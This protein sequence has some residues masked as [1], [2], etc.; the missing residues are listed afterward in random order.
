MT[1]TSTDDEAWLDAI[2]DAVVSDI[3][4]SGYFDQV[5]THEPKRKPG[6]GLTAAVWCDGIRPVGAESGLAI[7]CAVVTFIVR[8]FTNMLAEP[9]DMIDP[10]M[11]KAVSNLIRRW[12]D[13]FDFDLD[14]VVRNVDLLGQ[15]SSGVNAQAGYLDM[16]G[17]LFRVFD[18]TLPIICNDV[19]PQ[20]P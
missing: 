5:N 12:H 10:R 13:N 3:Q 19:W 8:I 20:V 16:D 2:L 15:A 14:P 11:M 7:S 18:I 17:A 1:L 9:Q 6:S 4:M